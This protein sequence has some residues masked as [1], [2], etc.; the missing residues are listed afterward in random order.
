MDDLLHSLAGAVRKEVKSDISYRFMEFCGGHTYALAKYAI[1]DILPENVKMTHGPGCPVCVLPSG[2]IKEVINLLKDNKDIILCTYGDV[3]R[4]P[5]NTGDS[6][7]KQKAR[8]ADV[9]IVYSCQDALKIALENSDKQVVFFAVGFET[10]APLTAAAIIEAKEKSLKNFSA[11]LCHLQ[12]PVAMRAILGSVHNLNGVIAPGHVLAVMGIKL[13]GDMPAQYKIPMVVSGFEASDLLAAI[14]M[15][16]RQVNNGTYNLENEYKRVV[17]ENGNELAMSVL[18]KVFPSFVDFEW[19]GL[20]VLKDSAFAIGDEYKEF[21]AAQRFGIKSVSYE[22]NKVCK[23]PAI[24]RGEAE[25]YDC[26]LFG[27]VCRP[28][29]P[30]GPCMV[31]GEGTC[32]A[33]FKYGVKR[34]VLKNA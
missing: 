17:T 26:P 32:G 27:K 19:R 3:L 5:D 21:D 2:K 20:G 1:P 22:E 33:F 25:P 23:C 10:T 6:L 15:L 8:G 16:V 4:V 11:F 12:T 7:F 18:R 14:L 34:G 30:V 31:S 13:L 29:S 28:E 9:R 24:I